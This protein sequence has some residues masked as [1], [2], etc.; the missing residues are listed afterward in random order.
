MAHATGNAEFVAEI[1]QRLVRMAVSPGNLHCNCLPMVDL[2][3]PPFATQSLF[4][5]GSTESTSALQ[6][7]AK[8]QDEMY[9]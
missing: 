6:P 5:K 9:L 2:L 7:E 3:L 1:E 8:S 4:E